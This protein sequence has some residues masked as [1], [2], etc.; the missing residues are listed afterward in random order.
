MSGAILD[1]IA[2]HR[3]KFVSVGTLT[4]RPY[5]SLQ[6]HEKKP[7]PS[8]GMRLFI[9]SGARTETIDKPIGLYVLRRVRGLA[10]AYLPVPD[11]LELSYHDVLHARELPE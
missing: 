3:A 5:L 10:P 2:H 1:G 7:H 6:V 11:A 8:G 4:K 9:I